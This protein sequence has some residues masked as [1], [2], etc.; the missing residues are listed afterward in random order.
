MNNPSE[1]G[2]TFRGQG[3][4]SDMGRI[5]H[6][7]TEQGTMSQ[8]KEKAADV[9]GQVKDKAQE[10][11]STVASGAQ[12]AWDSTKRQTREWAGE[13]ADTAQNAWEGF[14]DLI[15]RYPVASLCIAL[16]VGFVLGG[17]LGYS[18]RRSS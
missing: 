1:H 3:G 15:R 10:W 8:L 16:G 2:S 14:G 5:E 12:H 6:G 4:Q 17:G 7:R 13:V 11:G 9:A 18:A